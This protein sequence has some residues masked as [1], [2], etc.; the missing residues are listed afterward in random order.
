M[1]HPPPPISDRFLFIYFGR[2]SM[3][4]YGGIVSKTFRS[5]P[6]FVKPFQNKI[7]ILQPLLLLDRTVAGNLGILPYQIKCMEYGWNPNAH[8]PKIWTVIS[9]KLL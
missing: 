5:F 3:D 4:G 7:L 2:F 9:N 1:V 8:A 6:K